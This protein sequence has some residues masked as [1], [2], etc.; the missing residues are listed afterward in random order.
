[1]NINTKFPL[2]M[3]S[4]VTVFIMS[5]ICV[6]SYNDCVGIYITVVTMLSWGLCVCGGGII[7]ESQ[8][9]VDEN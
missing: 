6:M 3:K 8:N 1:M 9:V 7:L 5:N 2:R 4:E